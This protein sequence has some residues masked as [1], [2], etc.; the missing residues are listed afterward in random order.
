MHGDLNCTPSVEMVIVFFSAAAFTLI[1]NHKGLVEQYPTFFS[2]HDIDCNN[3]EALSRKLRE[4]TVKEW[5]ENEDDYA[6]FLTES[7]VHEEA[8]RFSQQGFFDGQLGDTMVLALSNVLGL[9]IFVI[10][11]IADHAIISI[12]PRQVLFAFPIYLAYN[13]CGPGHYDGVLFKDDVP[14]INVTGSATREPKEVPH[15]CTCGKNDKQGKP[16]CNPVKKKYTS[17]CYCPCYNDGNGCSD[18]CKCKNCHNSLGTSKQV[19]PSA[20][21]A[22]KRPRHSWQCKIPSSEEFAVQNEEI[23]SC[24]TRST[25]EFFALEQVLSHCVHQGITPSSANIRLIYKAMY[26]IMSSTKS[27]LP[28]RDLTDNDIESFLGEHEH[29]REL[30]KALCLAHIQLEQDSSLNQM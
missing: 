3:L 9:P 28:I 14:C 1:I 17:V 8:E 29:N 18:I 11:S 6:G 26:E 24:G 4:L 25:L 2:S 12:I 20:P 27:T 5:R 22:K 23:I 15:F 30:Y 10:T 21:P 19:Q 13:H 16:H 7:S